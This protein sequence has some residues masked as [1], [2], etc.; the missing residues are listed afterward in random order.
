M[1]ASV[2]IDPA[3]PTPPYEQLRRQLATLITSGTLREG[4]RLAPVRQLAADLALAAGTV[5]R[6]YRALETEGL[7][8][9]ARGAGTRVA[10]GAHRLSAQDRALR[11]AELARQYVDAASQL[12]ADGETI[13]RVADDA[14]RAR[15]R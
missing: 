10:T 4:S 9:T 15:G 8:R 2:R 7:V 12:G 11:L 1:S 6:T 13:R 14:I 5:A 3:D